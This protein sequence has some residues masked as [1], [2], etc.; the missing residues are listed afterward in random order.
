[1]NLQNKIDEIIKL[2]SNTEKIVINE[3]KEGGGYIH[4]GLTTSKAIVAYIRTIS[5]K[6]HELKP[7][8]KQLEWH[9]HEDCVYAYGYMDEKNDIDIV[10]EIQKYAEQ[11][12]TQG[13]HVSTPTDDDYNAYATLEEAKA[14]AQ[15]HFEALILS[16]LE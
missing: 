13:Y 7:N 1:M 2:C 14:A 8:V 4:A 9:T 3:Y 16:C 12:T 10:Y 15:S 11:S 6:L 5:N